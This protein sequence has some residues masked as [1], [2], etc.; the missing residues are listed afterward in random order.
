MSQL[1]SFLMDPL[2]EKDE[3]ILVTG[4]NGFIGTRVVENLLR[5]GFQR[6]T[7]M[8]RSAD[9]GRSLIAKAGNAS[10]RLSIV[11]GNLLTAAD[12]ARAV[13]DA[14]VIYHLAA[15]ADKSF[16]G[17]Y[18][19]TVVATRN[20]LDAA[21]EAR[22]VKRFVNVSS[23]AVYS[24]WGLDKGATLDESCPVE[25]VP[26]I[27]HEPYCYAKA[28]QEELVLRYMAEHQVPVVIVRPGAVYGPRAGQFL[29]PRVGI[30]TFGFFLHLG[31][32]NEIPLIY[33]DNCAEGIVLSGLV[34]GIDGEVFNLVDDEL[35]SS[36]R[37][38]KMY[39]R[40]VGHFRSLYVPYE[41]FYLFSYA[42]EKYCHWSRGQFQPVFNRR[43]AAA[44]WKGNR[45]SNEKAKRQLGWQPQVSFEEGAREH[46]AYFKSKGASVQ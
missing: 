1:D 45:Y 16:S 37:F 36:R 2:I 20:L 30:D 4:A 11:E 34:T 41:L 33:V 31:G 9:A 14:A 42:W 8:V 27:R 26:H 6:I 38:L 13:G 29:T 5:R 39:K 3:S 15:S 32:G 43:R 25:S 7:C 18:F 10:G 23:F 21:V 46:F 40:Q 17:S 12:C 22:T 24:N 19:S 44:Y 28:K 35:P